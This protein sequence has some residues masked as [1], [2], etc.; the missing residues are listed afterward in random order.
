MSPERVSRRIL[1]LGSPVSHSVSPSMQNAAFAHEK[2]QYTYESKEVQSSELPD[3][4]Q[5][6]RVGTFAG[7][8]VTLPHKRAVAKLVDEKT[9]EA[10]KSGSVNT[11]IRLPNGRICGHDT[12]GLGFMHS[13]KEAGITLSPETRVFLYGAGGAAGAVARALEHQGLREITFRVRN[14]EK[15]QAEFGHAFPTATFLSLDTPHPAEKAPRPELWIHGTPLGLHVGKGTREWDD[16]LRHMDG[17]LPQSGS[18]AVAVDLVYRPEETIFAS[19]AA[20]RNARV[21]S[22]LGML[23]HQGALS[24]TAWTGHK[25]PLEIMW[26]AARKALTTA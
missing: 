10:E 20:A 11:L 18:D 25:A 8:N 4:I 26:K 14:K 17:W 22:G 16:T 21:I 23:V 1:L 6:L 15:A 9:P 3:L 12:D 2:L 13:L 7:A 19:L 24:F 5:A